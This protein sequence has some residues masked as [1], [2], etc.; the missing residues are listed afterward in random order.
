MK[1]NLRYFMTL[2]LMMVASVGWAQEDPNWSY[3]VVNGDKSKLNT[4]NKTFTVDESHVWNYEVTPVGE[5][6]AITIGSYSSTYAIK[7]GESKS[8]YFNPVILS[9]EAFYD[10]AVTKV[11]LYVKHNGKKVGTLTVTQGDETIGTATTENTSDWI[12]VECSETKKGS[13]GILSI[14]YEVDQALY[15]NKI[16]V[17]YEDGGST[18]PSINAQNVDLAY[19]ATSASI[20]YEIKNPVEG[21]VLTASSSENWLTVGTTIDNTIPLTCDANQTKSPRTATVT[22][23]YTY[24]TNETVTKSVTVTQA[25]NPNIVDN[26]S[27]ITAKGTYNV[28]GTIVAKSQRGFIVGDGTGYV[29]YYNQDY[30]QANYNIGD[31]VK[32][33]GS[34]DAYGGVFEFNNSTTITTATESDYVAEEPT[35]LTG[36]EM[37]ERV[38]NSTP[39]QL[40]SYVQYQGILSVSD[41]HYN[42]TNIEGA[43]T[44]IGS[45]SYPISTDF[46]SLNGKTVKV[47]GY[48]VG[49]SSSKYYNTLI[50]SIEEVTGASPVIKASDVTLEYDATS[51]SIPYSVAN[52]IEDQSISANTDADWISNITVESDK[53]T[54]TTTANEGTAERT[55]TVTLS[56]NG[57]ED[58]LVTVT[59]KKYVADYATLPFSWEGGTSAELQAL[60][61]VTAEGLG[62]DYAASNAPYRVKFDTTGDFIQVK[63]NERPGVVTIGVKMLGGDNTSS[64]VVQESADGE[65]FNEVETLTISGN[66]N[67]VLSLNT[68]TEFDATSRYVRLYFTRG[69]NVGVGP[70]SIS[71]Y[72]TINFSIAKACTDGTSYFGTFYTDKPYVMPEGVTGQTVAVDA[73][74]KLEVN[75]A[76]TTGSVVPAET[77]LLMKATADGEKTALVATGGKAPTYTNMLKGTLTA[78]QMTEGGDKY[79]RLTMHNGKTLGF[80]YGAADGAAFKPGANKAYLAVPA[81]AAKEGFA[82][83]ETTG[84]NNV[85]VNENENG[86]IFNLAGQQMK[87]AVKGVYIKNGKK[88]IK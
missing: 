63:T 49:I 2:L 85:N 61:G 38:A 18:A 60:A 46:T 76:Y 48:Y 86:K 80:Y 17:W 35:A 65:T 47:S 34:V 6:P 27:D 26:I 79:Y 8:K 66:Q 53:V 72:A 15:V 64:I 40:S 24:N 11:R 4:E 10:K 59:Q 52:P 50:G 3:T 32:L 36:S 69:S 7:F 75:D 19:D 42:I 87:S 30:E 56:Y 45:I 12:Y 25:G 55:A 51:G 83:G 71:E 78:D 23:T 70:I 82:F 44:A 37:D 31:K 20:S 81:T 84:I 41:N 54:F 16:E 58:K 62:N 39:T 22:L 9:T 74:G 29:Y 57:A 33:S 67:A 13:G 77:P 43:T 1:K 5:S 14:K 88:Y 21:G 28:Q 68:T 73:D